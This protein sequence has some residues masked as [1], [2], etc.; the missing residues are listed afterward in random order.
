MM[1][2]SSII[3]TI[4]IIILMC[5]TTE[6]WADKSINIGIN[7]NSLLLVVD[8]TGAIVGIYPSDLEIIGDY[9]TVFV[10]TY[11]NVTV[12]YSILKC[13]AQWSINI[14]SSTFYVPDI[15]AIIR[16]EPKENI[17][18]YP[19]IEVTVREEYDSD[20]NTT[21]TFI[22]STARLY[23][24]LYI[25]MSINIMKIGTVNVTNLPLGKYII[26][27]L[28]HG[29]IPHIYYE[30]EVRKIIGGIPYQEK[31]SETLSLDLSQV[32]VSLHI[33]ELWLN[34]IEISEYL[35]QGNLSQGVIINP[36][37]NVEVCGRITQGYRGKL[38]MVVGVLD[39]ETVLSVTGGETTCKT[40]SNITLT[41]GTNQTIYLN[42][43]S[44]AFVMNLK[45]ENISIEGTIIS[46]SNFFGRVLSSGSLWSVL[47]QSLISVAGYYETFPLIRVEGSVTNTF[48][49]SFECQDLIIDREDIYNFVCEKNI[50]GNFNLVD[51][52]NSNF[53]V[54]LVMIYGENKIWRFTTVVRLMAMDPSSIA[55]Q[56]SMI[57]TYAS[58]TILMGIVA[59]LILY[60]VSHIKEMITA[61]PL[62]DSYMLRGALLTLV[63]AYAVLSIG[64]PLVH[65]VF[66][67]IVE[68]I[69]IL[70]RY[71]S[72]IATSTDIRASFANMVSYYDNL[73]ITIM[74][75]YDKEFITSIGRIMMW[76]Q[77]MSISALS[78][79]AVAI[80]LSTIWTPGAGIPFSSI[81][82]GIMSLVFG[83]ISMLMMQ[84]QMGIYVIV[85][86]TVTRV[87]I[88]IVTAIMMSLMVIGVILICIP[89]SLS[90]RIGEDLFGASILYMIVFPLIAPLSYAIYKHLM[91]SVAIQGPLST[92]SNICVYV[93]L[94]I[95]FAGFVP[96][97]V[98]MITF[99]VA[100]SIAVILIL[101]SLGYILTRTGV[102]TGIGEA[103]SSLV[104]RG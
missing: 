54:T 57:Y 96:F 93:P 86:I 80:A 77:I 47:L 71:I 53:T 101:G 21:I 68:N 70:N 44:G 37:Y 32:K 14:T 35:V 10:N 99:V 39:K 76:I 30:V 84:A 6:V 1:K 98:R 95:C 16:F 19:D 48:F 11:E 9:S 64:I 50:Y 5:Y 92:L 51:I 73:F 85:A 65:Y 29:H 88:F 4:L 102:A 40:I 31:Y 81:F 22:T 33:I 60:I 24:V 72:N 104:W 62:F 90:Q 94:P 28:F 49:G 63:V 34:K 26:D 3:I 83:I 17:A 23:I 82:S 45:Y 46:I 58:N 87:M 59:I 61:V 97:F 2:I 42:V 15:D 8:N 52:E 100:S 89:T 13:R 69:P 18:C 20:T 41:P 38:L 74:K 103:L 7:H 55:G 75:D 66:G 25:R 79:M 56:V 91:D 67:R 78:I 36:T 27:Y 43:R 12:R